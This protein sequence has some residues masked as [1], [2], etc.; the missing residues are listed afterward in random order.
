MATKWV[1][2]KGKEQFVEVQT[3]CPYINDERKGFVI[4]WGGT[5][6]W[7]EYTISVSDDKIKGYSECMDDNNDKK[8][9]KALFEDILAQI[10][11]RD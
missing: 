10:D 11:I 5:N 3:I 9:L 8:F 4:E 7:G 2:E 6:G 1:N